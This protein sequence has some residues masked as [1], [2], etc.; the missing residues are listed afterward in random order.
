LQKFSASW[1]FAWLKKEHALCSHLIDNDVNPPVSRTAAR[2]VLAAIGGF[3]CNRAARA[4]GHWLDGHTTKAP[5]VLKPA[6]HRLRPGEGE[7]GS[8]TLGPPFPSVCPSTVMACTWC[9]RRDASWRPA[10]QLDTKFAL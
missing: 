3:A 8:L 9:L 6:C 2:I 7:S 1:H 10:Q 4:K 5:I